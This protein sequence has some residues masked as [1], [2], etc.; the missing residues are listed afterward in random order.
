[1]SIEANTAKGACQMKLKTFVKCNL[2]F[3]LPRFFFGFES[4]LIVS[5]GT[6]WNMYSM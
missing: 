5:L 1:M 2:N 4:A 3:L 6:V